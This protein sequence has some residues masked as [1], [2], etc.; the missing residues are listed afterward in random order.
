MCVVVTV[1]FILTFA[2]TINVW[3]YPIAQ[4]FTKDEETIDLIV[5]TLPVLS[6]FII[7][8]A[9][10]GVQAG[11][12][13]ALGRQSVV[14]ITTLLCYYGIGLPLALL[15]GF[16]MG[17]G[18]IGFWLGYI[19]AMAIVDVVVIYL[20]IVSSWEANYKLEPKSAA[21]KERRKPNLTELASKGHST[22]LLDNE[23]NS[24]KLQLA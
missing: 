13:R 14:S 16:R 19:I 11:N 17:R 3:A 6:L 15:F 24:P 10:H 23:T 20:V 8:D 7:L 2:V 22:P 4:V 9:V 1:T 5:E 21:S 18:I 12:V